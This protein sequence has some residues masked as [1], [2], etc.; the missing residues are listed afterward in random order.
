MYK[1]FNWNA[2]PSLR[3][4]TYHYATDERMETTEVPGM[5]HD[6]VEN[7]KTWNRDRSMTSN[8]QHQ[9]Q[10]KQQLRRE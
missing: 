9:Q 8:S 5:V 10:Q 2:L 4:K 6:I 1:D 3:R 7:K